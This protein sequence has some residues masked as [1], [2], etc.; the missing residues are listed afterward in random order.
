MTSIVSGR[1][2]A[3]K[4]LPAALFLVFV[5]SPLRTMIDRLII[6]N[7]PAV[8]TGGFTVGCDDVSRAFGATPP[9]SGVGGWDRFVERSVVGITDRHKSKNPSPALSGN[10][11]LGS[12]GRELIQCRSIRPSAKID[13]DALRCPRPGPL[14]LYSWF[15][16]ASRT[17]SD[18][19]R[20]T[21]PRRTPDSLAAVWVPGRHPVR[22]R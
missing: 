11:K 21:C 6:E 22:E 20:H 13:R 7:K 5:L 8:R 2:S 15:R 1:Q 12:C 16:P 4:A 14:L 17:V 19:G 10:E 9:F 18:S 3:S